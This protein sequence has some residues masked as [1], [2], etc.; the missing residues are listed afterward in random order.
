MAHSRSDS[1]LILLALGAALSSVA[2]A[3]PLHPASVLTRR[4]DYRDLGDND[5]SSCPFDNHAAGASGCTTPDLSQLLPESLSSRKDNE[6]DDDVH[7]LFFPSSS[8][9]LPLPTPVTAHAVV[10]EQ[11]AGDAPPLSADELRALPDVKRIL[12]ELGPEQEWTSSNVIHHLRQLR[13]WKADME[14]ADGDLNVFDR[15]RS[16]Q[17]YSGLVMEIRATMD[18]PSKFDDYSLWHDVTTELLEAPRTKRAKQK[19]ASLWMQPKSSSRGIAALTTSGGDKWRFSQSAFYVQTV[20]PLIRSLAR[21][22]E[23]QEA[24]YHLIDEDLAKVAERSESVRR[25]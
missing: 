4:E 11:R 6:P 25:Q 16:G 22:P 23:V 19:A 9:T 17:I 24:L 3:A 2:V 5:L 1:I 14:D 21:E 13:N 15:T 10:L 7:H 20:Q 18:Q 12:H 8:G